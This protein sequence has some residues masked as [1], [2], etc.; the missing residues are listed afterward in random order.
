MKLRDL[1]SEGMF[2]NYTK[3]SPAEFRKFALQY[4][5]LDKNN[6]VKAEEDYDEFKI[7]YGFKRGQRQAEWKYIEDDM[8]L[9]SDMN[10]KDIWRISNDKH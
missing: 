6:L 5:K 3:M 4:K 2:R 1:L 9:H 8:K 7:Y 10:D